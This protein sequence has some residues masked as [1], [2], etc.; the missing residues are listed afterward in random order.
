[1]GNSQSTR[2]DSLTK[3]DKQTL[4][5]IFAE[6]ALYEH[7]S[8]IDFKKLGEITSKVDQFFYYNP[9]DLNKRDYRKLYANVYDEPKLCG[10]NCW[11]RVQPSFRALCILDYIEKR[12]NEMINTNARPSMNGLYERVKKKRLALVFNI[13]RYRYFDFHIQKENFCSF[14]QRFPI[15]YSMYA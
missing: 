5:N 4:D 3:K 15:L 2:N 14:Q 1:M 6:V 13:L 9:Y 8:D 12:M 11:T 7:V 10:G